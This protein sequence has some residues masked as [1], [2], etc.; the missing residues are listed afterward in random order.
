MKIRIEKDWYLCS[1]E[2][3]FILSL[4]KEVE[5]INKETGEKEIKLIMNHKTFHNTI[6]Q[7]IKDYLQ[8]KLGKSGISSWEGLFKKQKEYE[9][10]FKKLFKTCLNSMLKEYGEN[11][12]IN[13]IIDKKINKL[14]KESE[15]IVD[16]YI[17]TNFKDYGKEV[18]KALKDKHDDILKILDV[19]L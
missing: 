15:D 16:K 17:Q 14:R 1:D 7:V 18:V 10:E 8:M 19:K 6:E 5:V 11:L 3:Q 4:E 2:R 9:N 13:K 12:D